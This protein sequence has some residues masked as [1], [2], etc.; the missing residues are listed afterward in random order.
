MAFFHFMQ[1]FYEIMLNGF[2]QVKICKAK[3]KVNNVKNVIL[4]NCTFFT[5]VKI[6]DL[7]NLN[8]FLQ[9]FH[10]HLKYGKQSIKL[11]K[12]TLFYE[13]FKICFRFL[14]GLFYI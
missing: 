8:F 9:I 13:K 14:L 3:L 12:K 4:Q 10:I 7:Q 1:I 6:C 2:K 11:Q 5:T